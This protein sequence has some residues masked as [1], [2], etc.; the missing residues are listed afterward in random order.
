[1][2][3]EFWGLKVHVEFWNLKVQDQK[4]QVKCK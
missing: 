4:V 1:M 2:Q 3:V